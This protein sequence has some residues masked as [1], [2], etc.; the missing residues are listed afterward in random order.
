VASPGPSSAQRLAVFSGSAVAWLCGVYV[1]VLSIGLWTLPSPAHPIQDPWFTLMELLILAIA[2]AMVAWA[3]AL[4]AGAAAERKA[5]A[6]AAVAFMSMSAAVTCVVHF[7]ILT[8]AR[9]P[10]FAG[11]PWARLV[12]AFQ[13]PSVVYALDIL[14]WDVFFALGALCAALALPGGERRLAVVRSLLF[15]AAALSFLGLAG[16]LLADMRVR[17]IGIVG[18]AVLFPLAAGL[19]ADQ[20]RRSPPNP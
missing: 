13:W 6:L 10:A 19:L 2:P 8:L 1:I 3:V 12:F 4:H 14:A 7:S 16:L 9:A 18:Y 20:V 17:N 5:L 11:E 15:A